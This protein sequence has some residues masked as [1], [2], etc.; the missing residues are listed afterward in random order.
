MLLPDTDLAAAEPVC[1]R[2]GGVVSATLEE[3]AGLS[4]TLSFGIAQFDEGMK[5][6]DLVS[7]ADRALMRGKG[8]SPAA[9]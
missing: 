3:T 8:K 5:V 2:I 1:E 6:K 7:A 9:G 4:L